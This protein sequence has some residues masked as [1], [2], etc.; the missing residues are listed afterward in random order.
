MPA[1]PAR[2]PWEDKFTTPTWTVLREAFPKPVAPVL[3]HVRDRLSAVPGVRETLG[4]HGIPWRWSLKYAVEGDAVP[5]AFLVPNP[6]KPLL[7]VP[8]TV[9]QIDRLPQRRLPR[10][11]RDAILHSVEIDGV[12]WPAWEITSKAGADEVLMLVALRAPALAEA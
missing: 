10:H 5:M 4:W 2:A 8:M 1:S 3:E 9:G 6:A 7:A 11:I 12:R